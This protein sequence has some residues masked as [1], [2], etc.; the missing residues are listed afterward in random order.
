[1][2]GAGT[3]HISSVKKVDGTESYFALAEET[4]LCQ[5]KKQV[6]YNLKKDVLKQGLTICKCIPY[7]LKEFRKEVNFN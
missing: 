7:K 1:M 3:Y 6:E 2:F 4:G 5:N